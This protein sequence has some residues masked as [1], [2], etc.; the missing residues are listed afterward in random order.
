MTMAAPAPS[1]WMSDAGPLTPRPA[2]EGEVAA[3]VA[4]L[5]AGFTG[6][7]TAWHLARS[8]PGTRIVVCEAEV[9][10][11]GASGR[12]GGWCV[13]GLGVTLGELARRFG[14]DVAGAT[15]RALRRTVDAIGQDLAAAGIDAAWRKGGVLRVARGAHEVPVLHDGLA[16]RRRLGLAADHELLDE[17]ALAERVRIADARAAV[18]DPHAATVHPGRLVRGLAAAVER[19]GVTVHEGSP[20]TAVVPRARGGPA[21]R[22]PAGVVRADTVVLAGEAYLTRLPRL[23]RRTLPVYS[24][25]VLTEPLSADQWAAIG[26]EGHECISSQR[27]TVDYL[28]RTVDGRILFGGRGAPYHYGSS[29]DEGHDHHAATHAMLRTQLVDWF[30]ALRG[31]ACTHAWGGP[32]AVNR[33]WLLSVTHDGASGVAA[34]YGYAGQGVAASHLAGRALADLLS[35]RASDATALPFVGHQP[36]R[37]EPEPLR[38]LGARVVQRGL[39]RADARARASGRPPTGR[40][41]AERLA[42]H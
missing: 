13:A 28:S 34:A 31:V 20:V 38:W 12:N 25:V 29:T 4:I 11:W 7:W 35:G 8:A 39:A 21:L 2:L 16:V 22:T 42:R 30:P 41:L 18:F 3:D 6:L 40:T 33:D 32:L 14:D 17:A 10:G 5:G 26:W 1:F 15:V 24:L 36:R 27:L 9:A 23:R 37:W 19:L